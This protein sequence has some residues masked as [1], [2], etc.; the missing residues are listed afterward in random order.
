MQQRLPSLLDEPL[1][2]AHRGARAYAREN[3][4]EAFALGLRLGA[5]GLESDVWLTADGVPV[6]DHDGLVA[7]RQGRRRWARRTVPIGELDRRDLP[8]HIPT[9]AELLDTCGTSFHLSLD[10]KDPAAATPVIDVVTAAGAGMPSRTW[11]C[12][13]RREVLV[14]SRDRGVRLVESVRLATLDE[15]VER[16]AA[17]LA[18]D[19]IDALNLHHRDWSGGLVAL[20]HRFGRLAF[21][22]DLQESHLLEQALRMGLDAV[23]SDHPDRMMDAYRAQIGRPPDS[24]TPRLR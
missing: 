4:L 18:R 9:L 13:P 5:S 6:L 12:S 2:F 10:L 14:A 24:A 19:G 16:R 11:L 8:A 3:T 22:W 21:G 23:Y 7:P 1:T 20:V 17:A 15:G